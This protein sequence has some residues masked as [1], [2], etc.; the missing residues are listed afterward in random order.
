PPPPRAPRAVAAPAPREAAP[1]RAQAA[2]PRPVRYPCP[3][4][5]SEAVPRCDW[6]TYGRHGQTFVAARMLLAHHLARLGDPATTVGDVR[7]LGV[8]GDELLVDAELAGPG[9]AR[10]ATFLLAQNGTARTPD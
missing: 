5:G 6:C 3:L 1:E 8:V 7:L 9:G 10:V 4:H 2:A